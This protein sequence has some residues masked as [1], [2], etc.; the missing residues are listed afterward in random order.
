MKLL[1]TW[2]LQTDGTRVDTIYLAYHEEE[3]NISM[4]G[5]LLIYSSLATHVQD[6]NSGVLKPIKKG[7]KPI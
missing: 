6:I 3:I 5:E 2:K 7:D 4:R 1:Q